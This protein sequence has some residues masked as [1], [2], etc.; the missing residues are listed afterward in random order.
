MYVIPVYV[1][2]NMSVL[3]T[4]PQ[5]VDLRKLLPSQVADA[6]SIQTPLQ[7][8]QELFLTLLKDVG[9]HLV[10]ASKKIEKKNGHQLRFWSKWKH[11]QGPM[12]IFYHYPL[13]G[14]FRLTF[15]TKRD[16]LDVGLARL[17]TY[18]KQGNH[19]VTSNVKSWW[20]TKKSHRL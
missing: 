18:L 11:Y 1:F 13:A 20:G 16:Y 3:D 10:S 4:W 8:E 7:Q 9:L 14:F 15:T 5:V 2:I 12:M 17:E 19:I 6:K